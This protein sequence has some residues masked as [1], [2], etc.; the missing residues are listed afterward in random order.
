MDNRA[1]EAAIVAVVMVIAFNVFKVIYENMK[2]KGGK[3]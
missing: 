2:G 3:K 1:I